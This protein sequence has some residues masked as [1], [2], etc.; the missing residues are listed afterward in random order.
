M[1]RIFRIFWIAILIIMSLLLIYWGKC[2]LGI[3]LIKGFSWEQRFPFLNVFQKN[4]YVI[5]PK[6]GVLLSSTFD[7]M[8]P[9]WPWNNLWA[10]MPGTVENRLVR[11]G[12]KDSFCLWV[13]SS[14]SQE[15][16]IYHHHILAVTPG[17]AFWYTGYGRTSGAAVGQMSVIL[18]DRNK[19]VL[20]W[21][22]AA[23]KV[24]GNAWSRVSERFVVPAGAGY[25]RFQLTGYGVGEAYFDDIQ[26]VKK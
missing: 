4:E 2:Q 19:Q 13:Q 25:L 20:D 21:G 26:F 3:N 6:P 10:R 23:R 9:Y 15:W 8:F 5:H 17:N 24:Q 16:A 1:K 12:L 22:F 7:E 14:S 18:Y 11:T